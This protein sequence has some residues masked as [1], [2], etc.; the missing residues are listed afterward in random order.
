MY[1]QTPSVFFFFFQ[2]IIH[3]SLVFLLSFLN[4]AVNYVTN[5]WPLIT[6]TVYSSY[7]DDYVIERFT[8]EHDWRIIKRKI[9]KNYKFSNCLS[10]EYQ[11]TEI[12]ISMKKIYRLRKNAEDSV[13]MTES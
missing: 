2:N 12:S 5:H 3:M 11:M 13:R 9:R 10:V 7:Q 8:N 1:L 6:L 4:Q